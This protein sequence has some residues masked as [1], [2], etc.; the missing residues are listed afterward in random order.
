MVMSF[1]DDIIMSW[2]LIVVSP[3]WVVSVIVCAPSW[4]LIGSWPMTCDLIACSVVTETW[5]LAWC[6]NSWHTPQSGVVAV[7]ERI[8]FF[9]YHL[10]SGTKLLVYAEKTP[11]A[12]SLNIS[13]K[14]KKL[15][16]T[17]TTCKP[18]LMLK[19]GQIKNL[20]SSKPNYNWLAYTKAYMRC[21][22]GK[23]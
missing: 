6:I 12:R 5:E 4:A 3:V 13:V 2:H 19:K 10:N 16:H 11:L 23:Q 21:Q 9:Y 1:V 7:W 17:V 22:K 20:L 18:S 14:Y 15:A 8:K